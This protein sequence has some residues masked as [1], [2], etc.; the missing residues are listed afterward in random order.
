MALPVSRSVNRE[1]DEGMTDGT[2]KKVVQN[3]GGLVEE[4]FWLARKQLSTK[5]YGIVESPTKVLANGDEISTP[6]TVAT[7]DPEKLGY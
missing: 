3:R 4:G 6:Y 5:G 1:L 7:K 2:Y